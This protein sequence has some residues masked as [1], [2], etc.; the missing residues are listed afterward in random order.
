MDGSNAE[1]KTAD[2]VNLIYLFNNYSALM[3]SEVEDAQDQPFTTKIPNS[4]FFV[5]SLF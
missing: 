4:R 3:K 2:E 1:M 5:F